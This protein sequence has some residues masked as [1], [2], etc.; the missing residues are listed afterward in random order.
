MWG[1]RDF[2]ANYGWC[3]VRSRA[4][5]A[6]FQELLNEFLS[7]DGCNYPEGNAYFTELNFNLINYCCNFNLFSHL[8]NLLNITQVFPNVAVFLQGDTR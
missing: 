2:G 6:D 4:N 8:Q 1:V 5:R 3:D 7:H